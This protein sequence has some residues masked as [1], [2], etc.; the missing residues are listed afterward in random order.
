LLLGHSKEALKREE[1]KGGARKL[2]NEK[3]IE[4]NTW[5]SP[6][7]TSLPVGDGIRAIGTGYID[8]EKTKEGRKWGVDGHFV[9]FVVILKEIGRR[10][11]VEGEDPE[12]AVDVER[13]F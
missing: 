8:G 12:K 3:P 9:S 5:R 1:R 13:G 7:E 2:G 6:K 11:G 4:K 10:P